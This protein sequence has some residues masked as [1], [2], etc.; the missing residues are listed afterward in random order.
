MAKERTMNEIR[1]T[2]E[3]YTGNKP[4]Q[5]L[6][7]VA[8]EYYADNSE[9]VENNSWKSDD[10]L[11]EVKNNIVNKLTQ[12]LHDIFFEHVCE[13]MNKYHIFNM[14]N[15]IIDIDDPTLPDEL[16]DAW[17]EYYHGAHGDILGKLMRSITN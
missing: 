14:E 15:Y 10:P 3:Y 6:S 11:D 4:R 8:G 2:K 9:P 5:V 13:E 17:F 16:Q 1:Q 7:D 12:D